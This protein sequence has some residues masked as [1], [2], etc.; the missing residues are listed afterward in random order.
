MDIV[1]SI[2]QY[3]SGEMENTEDLTAFFQELI[4]SKVIYALQ[5]SYYRTAASLQEA[6]FVSGL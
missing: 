5:G 2:I 1:D 4:D 3:E 6:G